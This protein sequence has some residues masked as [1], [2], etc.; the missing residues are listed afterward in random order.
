MRT[1]HRDPGAHRQQALRLGLPG[2]KH[3]NVIQ[4]GRL[5][6]EQEW[7]GWDLGEGLMNR[8]LDKLHVYFSYRVSLIKHTVCKERIIH[9]KKP[10]SQ[11]LGSFSYSLDVKC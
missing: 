5:F 2:R 11:F 4:I 3:R 10:L 6:G 1:Q 7:A 8:N 9:L